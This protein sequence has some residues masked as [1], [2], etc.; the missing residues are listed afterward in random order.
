MPSVSDFLVQVALQ[1]PWLLLVT[2]LLETSFVTGLFVPAGA[3]LSFATA[4]ALG[5]GSSLLAL[6]AAALSGGAIG[7]SVGFWIGRKGRERW[8]RG[9]G[10]LARVVRSHPAHYFGDRPFLSVTIPRL[11][12]FVRTT[13]PLAVGMSGISYYCYLRYEL[14]GLVLWCALYMTMGVTAGEGWHWV[15]QMFGL[16]GATVVVGGGGRRWIRGAPPVHPVVSAEGMRW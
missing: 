13:M 11:I 14:I 16:D 15:D 8:S 9:P 1:G 3:D 4:F 2:A 7:D 6:A 12:S 10:R 5:Q